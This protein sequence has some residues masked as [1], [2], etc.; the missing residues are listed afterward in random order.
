MVG[1]HP[2][3]ELRRQKDVIIPEGVEVIGER[4]FMNSQIESI[5]ISASVR[6]LK[7]EAFR[8]CELLG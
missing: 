8:K 3:Q 6:K 1:D 7:K 4:W 2:L 5:T